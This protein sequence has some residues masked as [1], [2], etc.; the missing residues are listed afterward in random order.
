MKKHDSNNCTTGG[1]FDFTRFYPWLI[2]LATVLFFARGMAF[3]P[4][5][6]LDDAYYVLQNQHLAWSWSNFTYWLE[7]P[8]LDLYTPLQM[9]SYMFDYALFGTEHMAGYHAHSILLH[10]AAAVILYYLL[11]ELSFNR[12]AAMFLALLFALSPQRIESVIWISERKD[13]LCGAFYFLA[14]LLFI[15]A[16]KHN[17][18]SIASL[19][20]M[21]LS[22]LAKPMAIS[23]PVV[24]V[25]LLIHERRRYDLKYISRNVW[26]HVL[27]AAAYI[28]FRFSLVVSIY[29]DFAGVGKNWQQTLSCTAAN[30]ARYAAKVFFPYSLNPIYPYLEV[31]PAVIAGIV[32]FVLILASFGLLLYYLKKKDILWHDFL[33]FTLC[34][35]ISLVPVVGFFRVGISHFADRYSY[36]PSAF[37]LIAVA[38]FVRATAANSGLKFRKII[39]VSGAF[40]LLWIA[41]CAAVYMQC[42]KDMRTLLTAA[43]NTE[44]PN[45]LALINLAAD[46]YARGNY[47][48]ADQHLDTIR[49]DPWMSSGELDKLRLYKLYLK[50]LLAL[51]FGHED[52]AVK[53]FRE[54]A[55]QGNA[56][57]QFNLGVCYAKGIGI[58]K[59]EAEA[60]KWYRK[61]AELG[62]APAQFNLGVCYVKGKGI[63]KDEAEAV[64]W[65]RKAAGQGNI[66]AEKAL[67]KFGE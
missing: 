65:Y 7:T 36:I 15:R 59:D 35:L 30:Y 54:V 46:E 38:F 16:V 62:F 20:A 18:M 58:G 63:E 4:Y 28:V 27:L 2:G 60:A 24:M 51:K 21:L 10:A 34:F 33:P 64:K 25:C 52:E 47:L 53:Y 19:A 11:L 57:A 29:S 40:Y 42:W 49:D 31:T 22:L 45:P 43:C 55:E 12:L 5:R 3:P 26:P 41:A 1:R 32:L 44:Q 66:N 6:E 56:N 37:L 9:F 8:C 17:R 23:L 67:Q 50:G 14:L 48:Q 61:A 39:I 13:V